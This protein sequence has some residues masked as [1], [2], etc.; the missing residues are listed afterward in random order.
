MGGEFWVTAMGDNT[1]KAGIGYGNGD[2]WI[3]ACA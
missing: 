2:G 3:K 1:V